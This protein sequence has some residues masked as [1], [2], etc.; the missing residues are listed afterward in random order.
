MEAREIV[1]T[2]QIVN[3]RMKVGSKLEQEKKI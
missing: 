1:A 3:A 2:G